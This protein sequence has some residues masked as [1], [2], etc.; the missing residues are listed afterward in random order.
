MTHWTEKTWMAGPIGQKALEVLATYKKYPNRPVQALVLGAPEFYADD[1]IVPGC[2]QAVLRLLAD[3]NPPASMLLAQVDTA[4]C[5]RSCSSAGVHGLLGRS[6]STRG[7]LLA[8][9]V[10]GVTAT[11]LAQW[12]S[13]VSPG[14]SR[15][16]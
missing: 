9:S 6:E 5:Q 3:A 14:A 4:L 16:K 2:D 11:S 8:W 13:P 7:A 12:S 10:K 15:G 1:A